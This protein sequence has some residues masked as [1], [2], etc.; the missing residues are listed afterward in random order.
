[1]RS[2][3]KNKKR[4]SSGSLFL[5]PILY[6][7]KMVE[8]RIYDLLEAKF[9]EPEFAD[10]FLIELSLQA[11]RMLE[12]IIDA[13]AGVTFDQC[14]L[15]SRYLE[16]HLDEHAWLGEDYTLEV[17]S[18]GVD[19]PL[20]LWRQYPKNIGRTLD[21]T[22]KDGNSHTGKLLEVREDG[23]SIEETI[24]RK[25]G[26]RNITEVVTRDIPAA[27]IEKTIV[28]ITFKE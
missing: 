24:K 13:D 28:K 15:I 11:G 10:C 2:E 14:R 6:L 23:L 26:K 17:S 18:P 22:L 20:K 3:W 19:R 12:V 5:L 25:E 16:S 9:A 7:Q 8:E 4:E 21:I 1:M 27:Q